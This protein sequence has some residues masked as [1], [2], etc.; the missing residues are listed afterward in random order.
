MT[1]ARRGSDLGAPS[2]ASA[3]IVRARLPAP[4][5]RLRRA[6]VS[7]AAAGVPAH[8][9]ML[10]PFAAPARLGADVRAAVA[11]VAGRHGPFDY[12]LAGRAVWPDTVYVR[13]EAEAPFVQLQ[14]DLARAFPAFPIYG[15]DATFEFVPHVTI[16]EGKGIAGAT[17]GHPAWASLPRAGRAEALEV[18]ARGSDGRWRRIWRVPLGRMAP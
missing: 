7:D 13:V 8:L 12:R 11:A 15:T 1:M 4:L 3:V 17:E 10:Y 14:A 2:E 5:E 16:A 18:I 6:S 9:T